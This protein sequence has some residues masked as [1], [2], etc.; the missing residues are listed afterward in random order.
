VT[1]G[2]QARIRSADVTVV[3]LCRCSAF[4]HREA[5]G[6]DDPTRLFTGSVS[7]PGSLRGGSRRGAPL[8]TST[9]FFSYL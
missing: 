6:H 8:L 7:W 3:S 4:P 9:V 2:V 5:F 1:H